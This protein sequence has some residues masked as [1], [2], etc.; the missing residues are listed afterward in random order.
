M[1]IHTDQGCREGDWLS[2]VS[3]ENSSASEMAIEVP[4]PH[5]PL[6]IWVSTSI[7]QPQLERAPTTLPVGYVDNAA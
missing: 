3:A 6:G 4:Y 7:A 5:K 2:S 1:G